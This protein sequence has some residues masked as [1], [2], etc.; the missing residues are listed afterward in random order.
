MIAEREATRLRMRYCRPF[1]A[2]ILKFVP[3]LKPGASIQAQ[4]RV[5]VDLDQAGESF[6][7]FDGLIVDD[8]LGEPRV[9]P[10]D[11]EWPD[12]L[13]P[14]IE[15]A[16]FEMFNRGRGEPVGAA[17]IEFQQRREAYRWKR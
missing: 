12:E 11:Q 5:R 16:A 4:L 15:R 6:A 7:V 13:R 2:R 14:S 3:N 17:A 1:A 10:A 8:G 9:V